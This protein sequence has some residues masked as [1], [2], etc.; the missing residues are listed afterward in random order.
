[1][2]IRYLLVLPILV[3]S[4]LSPFSRSARAQATL[5]LY[6]T[7]HSMGIIVTVAPT[8]DPDHDAVANVMY[9]ISGSDSTVRDFPCLAS[10]TLVLSG[11][12]SGWSL[13]LPTMCA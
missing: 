12:F 2:R 4:F 9:Q 11:A 8:D 3:G 5:E 13:A 7:F 10:V 1:M 6:G